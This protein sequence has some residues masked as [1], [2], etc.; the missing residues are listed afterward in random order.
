MTIKELV[1]SEKPTQVLFYDGADM[2]AAAG[3]MIGNKIICACCGATFDVDE[4]IEQA[5]EDNVTAVR[6]FKNW[7]NLYEEIAGDV[8]EK[9]V[10]ALIDEE[11]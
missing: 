4:V 7:V 11:D 10:P 6:W 1:K 8:N 9:D 2:A 5:R 3:I